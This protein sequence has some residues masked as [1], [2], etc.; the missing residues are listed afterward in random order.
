M[1]KKYQSTN[2]PEEYPSYSIGYRRLKKL[3]ARLGY[4]KWAIPCP[5]LPHLGGKEL[6]TFDIRGG[7]LFFNLRYP[8]EYKDNI[9]GIEGFFAIVKPY[10]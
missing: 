4:R 5:L 10:T 1:C 8:I 2:Y 9:M 7:Q 6:P 3:V